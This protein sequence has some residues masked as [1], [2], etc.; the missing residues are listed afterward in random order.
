MS[1]YSLGRKSFNQFMHDGDGQKGRKQFLSGKVEHDLSLVSIYRGFIKSPEIT[2][3]LTENVLMGNSSVVRSYGIEDWIKNNP[4][5][6]LIDET[7]KGRFFSAL[8]V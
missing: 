8:R 6:A 3:F 1:A 2:G 7:Q 4:D 5:G